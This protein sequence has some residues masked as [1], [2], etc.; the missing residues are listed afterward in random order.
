MQCITLVP[1]NYSRF[2]IHVFYSP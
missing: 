1:S 2:G